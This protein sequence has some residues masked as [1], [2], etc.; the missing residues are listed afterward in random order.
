M[1]FVVP[2]SSAFGDIY[3]SRRARRPSAVLPDRKSPARRPGFTNFC[4]SR[5]ASGSRRELRNNVFHGPEALL[6]K[7]TV[8]AGNLLRLGHKGLVGRLCKLGLHFD[9][10]VERPHTGKL[11]YVGFRI[12]KGLL[13]VVAIGA[14]N[15]TKA[16]L[17]VRC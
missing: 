10:L 15:S 12:L 11:L 1:R 4:G 16:V 17:Q 2:A 9:R 6:G 7:I 3:F 13:G 5:A 14:R 8:K